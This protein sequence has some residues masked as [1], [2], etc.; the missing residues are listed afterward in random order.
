MF[1]FVG[2]KNL[3]GEGGISIFRYLQENGSLEYLKTEHTDISAGFLCIDKEHARLFCVN[4][5]LSCEGIPG[6]QVLCYQ[7]NTQTGSL[8][9]LSKAN[10]HTVLPCYLHYI[11]SDNKI[12]VC[13]HAK[14]D[15][16]LKLGKDNLGAVC[17]SRIF[18]D[19]A[20]EVFDVLSDGTIIGPT[21]YWIAPRIYEAND[22]PHLHSITFCDEKH[23]AFVCDTGS[24]IIY[25]IS[26][27]NG[28]LLP[29][30]RVKAGTG[31]G[32][33]RYGVLHPRI[34]VAYFNSEKQN[35]LFVYR[36]SDCSL[37]PLQESKVIDGDI[38]KLEKSP[39]GQSAIAINR[40][41]STLYSLVRSTR[42][43]S[44]F[45][46][47][48]EGLIRLL[49]SYPV[50]SDSPRALAISPDEKY[51]FVSCSTGKTIIRMRIDNDGYLSNRVLVN[52]TL[53]S[54]GCMMFF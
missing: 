1:L 33:P 39:I 17:S 50:E 7:I 12:L 16:T 24:D 22:N 10:T 25:T 19:A 36:I 5:R 34:P 2:N 9:L 27:D 11:A 53:S 51:L 37:I 23:L 26:Y 3:F 45:S 21:A 41:G 30:G 20:I 48:Q 52:D 29:L 28:N 49:Q 44:V 15:W 35:A 8:T 14:R 38:S 54:P 42:S 6:G 18:D 13:N 40:A 4:E 47:S 43:V 32:A 31:E 46:V